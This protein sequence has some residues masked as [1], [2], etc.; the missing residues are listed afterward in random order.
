MASI[1]DA[2]RYILEVQGR[3]STM[4]LQKLCY[5][6]QA[7]SLVWDD[8]PLFDED[9]EAWANGPICPVLFQRFKGRFDLVAEDITDGDSSRLNDNQKETVG[10][11]LDH[12]GHR[13]IQYLSRLTHM[14]DPWIDAR[15]GYS[16]GESCN[17]IITKDSMAM[18]YGGLD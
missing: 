12:Y 2:A 3:T 15:K 5:Y 8:T 17:V 6:A 10:M 14:E 4:K 11:V 13:D 16:P 9:F 1:F 7:W 18:Y